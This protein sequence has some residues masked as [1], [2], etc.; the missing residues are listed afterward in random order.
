MDYFLVWKELSVAAASVY[1]HL[2]QKATNKTSHI[3]RSLACFFKELILVR[4]SSLITHPHLYLLDFLRAGFNQKITIVTCLVFELGFC[5][6]AKLSLL[7]IFW[8]Y[9]LSSQ[10]CE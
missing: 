3:V 8:R 2:C 9:I 7:P 1:L 5:F 10:K 6:L 4:R